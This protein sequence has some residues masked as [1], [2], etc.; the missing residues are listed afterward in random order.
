MRERVLHRLKPAVVVALH[1]RKEARMAWWKALIKTK[2]NRGHDLKCN[3]VF[4]VH[5][6]N[7]SRRTEG[8]TFVCFGLDSVKC[9]ANASLFMVAF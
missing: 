9:C 7:G 3:T 6:G 2:R 1:T 5:F 8:Y 4:E